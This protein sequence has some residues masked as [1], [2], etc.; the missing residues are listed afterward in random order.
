[1]VLLKDG[2][3]TT[4]CADPAMVAPNDLAI[5]PKTGFV[6]VSGQVGGGWGCRG[7]GFSGWGRRGAALGPGAETASQS[8]MGHG[9][10]A[11]H[12]VEKAPP[13]RSSALAPALAAESPP[14]PPNP[15]K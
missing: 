12:G 8:I 4:F 2:A 10:N 3:T 5:S 13:T 9:M 6:Y 15:P 14:P 1:V 7:L 11:G